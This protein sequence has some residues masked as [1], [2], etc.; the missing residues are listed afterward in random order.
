MKHLAEVPTSTLLNRLKSLYC[1]LN[2]NSF[3][4]FLSH[5][6]EILAGILGTA[7]CIYKF[8]EKVYLFYNIFNF[9]QDCKLKLGTFANFKIVSFKQG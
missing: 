3:Q 2:I 1:K 8:L 7:V 9:R 5:Y 6:C 4:E